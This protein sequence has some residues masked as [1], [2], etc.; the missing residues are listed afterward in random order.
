M[1]SGVCCCCFV[2]ELVAIVVVA[3]VVVVFDYELYVRFRFRRVAVCCL[4]V[5]LLF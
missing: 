3:V 1:V 4:A 2:V 5:P